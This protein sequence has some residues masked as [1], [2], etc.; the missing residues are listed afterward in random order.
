MVRKLL[1]YRVHGRG[2]DIIRPSIDDLYTY[3]SEKIKTGIIV[4]YI[5]NRLLHKKNHNEFS[6]AIPTHFLI[7]EQISRSESGIVLIYWDYG[8]RTQVEV[9]EAFF[10][11]ITFGIT[12]C[13]R[14]N[15]D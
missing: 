10:K 6:V 11:K 4:L 7:L 9:S 15:N 1:H 13:R 8:G 2:A 14:E 3:I 5:N 12:T